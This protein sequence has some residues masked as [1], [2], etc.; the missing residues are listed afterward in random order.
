M[1]LLTTPISNLGLLGTE[2]P[3]ADTAILFGVKTLF[4][5]AGVIYLLFAI[6]VVRQIGIMSKTIET[7]AV[8]QIRS[9]GWIHLAAS[10]LVLIY[11]FIVL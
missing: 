11:F 1:S 8:P 3:S 4:I 9:L 2:L 10:I 7:T 5:F 6:L